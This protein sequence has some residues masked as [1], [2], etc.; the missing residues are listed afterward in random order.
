MEGGTGGRGEGGSGATADAGDRDGPVGM[1][2]AVG[3]GAAA[4]LA[5]PRWPFAAGL[6]R[7]VTAQMGHNPAGVPAPSEAAPAPMLAAREPA[8][9]LAPMHRQNHEPGGQ[10]R[11]GCTGR[12]ELPVCACQTSPP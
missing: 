11:G 7:L 5:P 8:G 6:M 9:C 3:A 4:S 10:S 1:V 2:A 12:V